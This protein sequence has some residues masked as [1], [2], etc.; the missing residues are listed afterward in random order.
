M[1]SN[2]MIDLAI[3]VC[4]MNSSTAFSTN[5]K[6]DACCCDE[7]GGNDCCT[8]SYIYY[9]TPKFIQKEKSITSINSN[10]LSCSKVKYGFDNINIYNPS[11]KTR[12]WIR[13]PKRC[14]SISFVFQ[15]VKCVWI[16]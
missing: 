4:E 10:I 16:I 8:T 12:H 6:T 11:I 9:F 14:N 7:V 1:L 5:E 13:H 3:E 15:E 2:G